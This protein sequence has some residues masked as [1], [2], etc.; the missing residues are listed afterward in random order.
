MK[1]NV[2]ALFCAAALGVCAVAV[3]QDVRVGAQQ[4]G[5]KPMYLCDHCSD[6]Q[7]EA[8][9]RALGEGRHL[10]VDYNAPSL[11]VY[12][13]SVPASGKPI[14]EQVPA[15][16]TELQTF[17]L[18]K[19]LWNDSSPV[20]YQERELRGL[21]RQHDVDRTPRNLVLAE[22]LQNELAAGL[23]KLLP[24]LT[25]A[26]LPAQVK[27]LVCDQ[28][29]GCQTNVVVKDSPV[30]RE[31]IVNLEHGGTVLFGWAKHGKPAVREVRDVDGRILPLQGTDDFSKGKVYLFDGDRQAKAKFA[32]HLRRIGFDVN[33]TDDGVGIE[34]RSA[35]NAIRCL[36][37]R[38][39]SRKIVQN[40][41][42][43]SR[44]I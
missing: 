6:A 30:D 15:S 27:Q 38:I 1:R 22:A 17:D 34:C 42:Q 2:G 25:P 12:E 16:E 13:Q 7:Y 26:P 24:A 41:E 8:A 36:D 39:E 37:V 32:A 28:R 10:F 5:E 35:S 14:V 21:L 29:L 40:S 23:E 20:R 44:D 11:R 3:S 43:G 4:P 9:A 18:V 19:R 31:V 33:V